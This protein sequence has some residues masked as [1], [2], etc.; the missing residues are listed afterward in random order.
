ME[1]ATTAKST[2]GRDKEALFY[3]GVSVFDMGFQQLLVHGNRKESTEDRGY[4]LPWGC[5]WVLL[6]RSATECLFLRSTT[7]AVVGPLSTMVLK[8]SQF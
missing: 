3:R 6:L 7:G 2:E 1:P 5:A 4:N 8:G